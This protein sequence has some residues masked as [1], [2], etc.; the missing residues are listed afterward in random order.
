MGFIGRFHSCV[1]TT[2]ILS[3]LANL[4][5]TDLSLKFN[6]ETLL[7]LKTHLVWAFTIGFIQIWNIIVTLKVIGNTK[8]ITFCTFANWTVRG[9][10]FAQL[11]SVYL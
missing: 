1:L 2:Q 6:N 7:R 10:M 4:Y 8:L 3:M 11:V 9:P 5:N